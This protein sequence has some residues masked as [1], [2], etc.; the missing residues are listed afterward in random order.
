ML[1]EINTDLCM[2]EVSRKL[3]FVHS[4]DVAAKKHFYF[5]KVSDKCNSYKN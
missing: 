5:V 4:D 1:N 3:D 2:K